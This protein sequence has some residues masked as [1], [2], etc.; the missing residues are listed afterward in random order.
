MVASGYSCDI[1]DN[2]NNNNN[3]NSSVDDYEEEAKDDFYFGTQFNM[4]LDELCKDSSNKETW[5]R[6]HL[7]GI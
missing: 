1:V 2:K 6:L 3:N 7:L 5:E 4:I